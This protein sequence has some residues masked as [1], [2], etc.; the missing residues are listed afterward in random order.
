MIDKSGPV[1]SEDAVRWV[2]VPEFFFGGDR[3]PESGVG[4]L[5]RWQQLTPHQLRVLG[6]VERCD[7]QDGLSR[8]YDIVNCGLSCRH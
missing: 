3:R 6:T 5:G 4:F 1:R 8:H 2:I 7:T